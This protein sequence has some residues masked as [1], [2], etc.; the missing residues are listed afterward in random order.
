MTDFDFDAIAQRDA[1]C[2]DTAGLSSVFAELLGLDHAIVA[3]EV[4]LVHR[5]V[6]GEASY[7]KLAEDDFL[8]LRQTV[9]FELKLLGQSVAHKRVRNLIRALQVCGLESLGAMAM[10][11]NDVSA[12]R[13]TVVWES[14]DD[15]LIHSDGDSVL[16]IV[17]SITAM[18]LR[19]RIM[20]AKSAQK[21]AGLPRKPTRTVD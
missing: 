10:A 1:A 7:L 4:G 5:T 18:G 11:F 6:G 8:L 21:A 9:V 3:A 2:T 20:D 17:D 12:L 19:D 13:S 14:I 16:S 15:G